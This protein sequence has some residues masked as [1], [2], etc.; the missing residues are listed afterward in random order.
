MKML[1]RN[2]KKS[3]A[4]SK[5][6]LRVRVKK[7]RSRHVDKFIFIH[8]N[9]TGGTSIARALNLVLEHKTSLQKI[10]EVGQ[11][12]W[13]NSYTFAFVRNPWDK[14]VS[15]YHYRIQTNQTGLGVEP[16]EFREWVHLA[17]GQQN[18]KYYD[19]PIMFMPQSD[20]ITDQDGSILVDFVGRFENINEDFESICRSIKRNDLCLPHV[21]SSK[22]GNYR[23]YYDQET[24]K[25]IEKWFSKDLYNFEYTF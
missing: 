19:K 14:V 25:I 16:I 2:A 23:D 17:Y 3:Y 4:I 15:H 21:K 22:R 6:K 8:I 11:S 10:T 5:A 7:F 18:P 9:K 20:W 13:N 12:K 24:A 1:V